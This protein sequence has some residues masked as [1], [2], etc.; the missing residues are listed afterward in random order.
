MARHGARCIGVLE[1]DAAIVNPEGIDPVAL[2]EY[3]FENG[4][5]KGFPGAQPYDNADMK[6]LLYE[7]CDIL[8]PAA[9][10]RQITSENAHRIQARIIAEVTFSIYGLFIACS[11][12]HDSLGC[13]WSDNTG[14]R[15]NSF[16]KQ[17][18]CHSW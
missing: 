15:C 11:Y 2:D 6:E 7:P 5:I 17:C 9:N 1:W 8:V 16:E 10:E 14:S 4:T 13:Q 18:P 12:I 3:K